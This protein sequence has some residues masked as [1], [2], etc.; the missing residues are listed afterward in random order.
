MNIRNCIPVDKFDIAAIE[1]AEEIGFPALNAILGDLLEWIQDA[2]W[3]VAPKVSSLLAKSDAEILP[4]ILAILNSDDGVWKY[5]TLELVVSKLRVD[6]LT[7]LEEVLVKLAHSP[8][9]DDRVEEVDIAAREVL[10][11][12]EG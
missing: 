6:V 2:N 9:E 12:L 8:T 7:E 3:P 10:K 5:W 11:L 1:Q 4:H